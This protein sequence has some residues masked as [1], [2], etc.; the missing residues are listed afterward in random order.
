[1]LMKKN[2]F[3]K[4]CVCRY[5]DYEPRKNANVKRKKGCAM[6]PKNLW[7][8]LRLTHTN[9]V[10]QQHTQA[11]TSNQRARERGK[12]KIEERLAER[13]AQMAKCN[14]CSLR[15]TKRDSSYLIRIVYLIKSILNESSLTMMPFW[16]CQPLFSPLCSD[17][18]SKK[19]KNVL[20]T[21][22]K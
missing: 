1:M 16:H 11:H 14:K 13:T 4:L 12:A 17:E 8:S 21:S 19:A 7:L 15:I 22:R 10:Y 3:M 6:L 20:Y 5:F 2:I 18:A 9:A